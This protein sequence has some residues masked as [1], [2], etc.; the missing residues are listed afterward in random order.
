M[1]A[2]SVRNDSTFGNG[3]NVNRDQFNVRID[4]NLSSN[5]KL[6]FIANEREGLVGVNRLCGQMASTER[7]T[8]YRT[9]ITCPWSLRYLSRW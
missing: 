9:F 6:S 8:G 7:S 3:V 4:H 5:H 1:G 2:S